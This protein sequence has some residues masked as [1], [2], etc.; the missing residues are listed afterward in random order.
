MRKTIK[1]ILATASVALLAA[2][3]GGGGG[4]GGGTPTA[5]NAEGFWNGTSSNGY[6]VAVAILENGETWGIYTSGGVIY[7]ALYGTSS[8]TGNTFSANGSDYNLTNWTV[9]SGS[10]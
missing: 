2:C 9:S 5:G 8:S 10:Y 7:G 4:G 3:G 1:V 6:D